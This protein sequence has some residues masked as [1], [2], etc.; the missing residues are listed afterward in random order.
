MSIVIKEIIISD[1]LEKF[2]EKVNFNFDQLLLAGG[3][4]Q[5]PIGPQGAIGPVGP[6]GDPGNK[7]YVGCTG[8]SAAIG[9]TLFQGDLFLQNE[10]GAS[11]AS[12]GDVYEFNA[13]TEVFDNTGLNLIGPTGPT[14][15]NGDNLSAAVR[16]GHYP[17][18]IGG[19]WK[20]GNTSGVGQTHN[21]HLLKGDSTEEYASTLGLGIGDSLPGYPGGPVVG[22]SRDTLWLGGLAS[23]M[24]GDTLYLLDEQPKIYIESIYATPIGVTAYDPTN[25]G[26]VWGG[27]AFGNPGTNIGQGIG[28]ADAFPNSFGN[29]LMDSALNIRLTNF[30]DFNQ[31]SINNFGINT[32]KI[33]IESITSVQ[34]LG[35][36]HGPEVR[37]D[38]VD[39][40]LQIGTGL[41]YD[42]IGG[43]SA[44]YNPDG[45]L[46]IAGSTAT[47]GQRISHI[48]IQDNGLHKITGAGNAQDSGNELPNLYLTSNVIGRPRYDI[49]INHAMDPNDNTAWYGSA[50]AS[51][52]FIQEGMVDGASNYI[53]IG[54]ATNGN[55]LAPHFFQHGLNISLRDL[56]S[57]IDLTWAAAN[58]LGLDAGAIRL[59]GTTG[60]QDGDSMIVNDDTTGTMRWM[61]TRDAINQEFANDNGLTGYMTY[62]DTDDT[63]NVCDEPSM[64]LEWLTATNDWRF[65]DGN[66]GAN[67]VLVDDGTGVGNITWGDASGTEVYYFD[68]R[69]A[70]TWTPN[71][72]ARS[73]TIIAIAGGGG[74]G[75]GAYRNDSAGSDNNWTT[76]GAGGGGGQMV[77]KDIVASTPTLSS[78]WTIFVGQGGGG[79]L[80]RSQLFGDGNG[81]AGDAGEPSFV[82]TSNTLYGQPTYLIHAQPGDGGSGGKDGV[83]SGGNTLGAMGD[84]QGFASTSYTPGGRPGGSEDVPRWDSLYPNGT[85]VGFTSAAP[86]TNALIA[87]YGWNNSY[88]NY[89]NTNLGMG[90]NIINTY[91]SGNG[92]G[93]KMWWPSGGA[94]SNSWN[95]FDAAFSANA[96]YTLTQPGGGGAGGCRLNNLLGAFT[97]LLPGGN[98]GGVFNAG[99]D[100]GAGALNGGG[101]V[102]QANSGDD[103]HSHVLGIAGGGNFSTG[104][105]CGSGGGGGELNQNQSP[106]NPRNGGPGGDGGLYGGGGGGGGAKHRFTTGVATAGKQP[107]GGQG[108]DGAQGVVII[109]EHT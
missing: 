94:A 47:A 40:A 51:T 23:A 35:A 33:S 37:F 17:F 59:R 87:G 108:G 76:G 97:Q 96:P 2:M 12:Y 7:W 46:L 82:S 106:S 28:A 24:S 42:V 84:M 31:A 49:L 93:Y 77:V 43:T 95:G 13:L 38:E 36:G 58:N 78:T 29:L 39:H 4:P 22:R 19:N 104:Q 107:G 30:T 66:Q 86:S 109:I 10:C 5:G 18:A 71:P 25:I 52:G 61:S 70:S 85:A 67:R 8:T 79:G 65:Q 9:V 99:L 75:G 92:G 14:G 63:I 20:A 55:A 34:L 26:R 32:N 6:K 45:G 44:S 80:G 72:L 21:F 50:Q 74:G 62:W 56:A 83:Y 69:G 89:S 27:I 98:G 16:L 41:Y 90:S 3:G 102:S 100:G 88:I 53:S 57:N 11:G 81:S 64:T 91:K 48:A 68:D 54:T 1:N 15:G 60:A 73:W 105:Y 103:G 101:G